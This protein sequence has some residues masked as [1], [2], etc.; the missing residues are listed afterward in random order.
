M[1]Y[2]FDGSKMGCGRRGKVSRRPRCTR[3]PGEDSNAEQ[4]IPRR[5]DDRRARRRRRARRVRQRLVVDEL[6][7]GVEF[8]DVPGQRGRRAGRGAGSRGRQVEGHAHG[9]RR[10]E[11]PPE[12]VHRLRRQ[13]RRGHGRRP[14]QGAHRRHGSEGQG[15]ERDVRWDHPGPRVEEVRPRNVVVHRHQGAREDGRLRDLP[16]GGHVL[17]RQGAGRPDDQHARRPLRP[18]GRCREGHDAGHGR[19][20][21]GQEV[22]G[23]AASP[24]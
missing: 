24:A 4:G 23:G 7:V 6:G 20:R 22:H 3:S 1:V 16:L 12:R 2:P 9:R 13:D 17:L 8:L 18:Q 19:R 14:G 15:G 5:S 10:R 11:L 21:A